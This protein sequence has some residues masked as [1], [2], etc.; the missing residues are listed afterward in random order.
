MGLIQ[1]S[2]WPFIEAISKLFLGLK[3]DLLASS[4]V[5]KCITWLGLWFVFMP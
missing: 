1:K 4:I 5:I 2:P 3:N